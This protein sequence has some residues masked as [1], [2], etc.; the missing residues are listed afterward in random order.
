MT[1]MRAFASF[2]CCFA[3]AALSAG[4][5]SATQHAAAAQPGVAALNIAIPADE[6]TLT[7]YTYK[8]GYPGYALL[9][10]I[11]DTVEQLD[12]DNV[13]RPLLA[14]SVTA[15]TDGSSY[16]ITLR[17]DIRWHDGQPLTVDGLKLH[18]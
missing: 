8:F 6:G 3:L 13:P 5:A 2:V 15:S 18:Y 4:P 14:K 12:A 9:S 11:Y 10:L 1:S 7:P 17:S 16:E